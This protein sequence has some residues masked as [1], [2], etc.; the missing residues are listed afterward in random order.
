[1]LTWYQSAERYWDDHGDESPEPLAREHSPS[2]RSECNNPR[3]RFPQYHKRGAARYASGKTKSNPSPNYKGENGKQRS[4]VELYRRKNISKARKKKGQ[5]IYREVWQGE[6][7]SAAR[8]AISQARVFHIL[9]ELNTWA[10]ERAQA[11]LAIFEAAA[12]IGLPLTATSRGSRKVLWGKSLICHDESTSC[13]ELI[14]FLSTKSSVRVN[15]TSEP[16]NFQYFRQIIIIIQDIYIM[17][18]FQVDGFWCRRL[19]CQF[20]FRAIS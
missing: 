6:P 17:I 11:R 19:S 18:V 14:I 20:V 8:E 15:E 2:T 10:P 12:K 7:G 3:N 13:G 16:W 9:S 4:K 5:L 1:M